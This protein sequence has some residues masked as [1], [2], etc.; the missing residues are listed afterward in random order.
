MN[1]TDV[2]GNPNTIILLPV[3]NS[4]L[5]LRKVLSSIK[6][7]VWNE[8]SHLLVLDNASCDDSIHV[9][10]DFKKTN[11]NLSH[12]IVIQTHK[13]N[14]GYGGSV[15]WGLNWALSRNVQYVMI[16]HSDDQANWGLVSKS[17]LDQRES[18]RIVIASRLHEEASMKGYSLKRNFGNRFFKIVTF[19]ATG[20]RM[21]DPGSAIVCFPTDAIIGIDFQKFDS[22]YL[23]HP[24]LNLIL[25]SNKKFE[26]K[27]IPLDWHDASTDNH[28]PLFRYGLSLMVFLFRVSVFHR[29]LRMSINKSVSRAVK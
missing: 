6:L 8:I 16:L 14:L 11:V 20:I 2:I 28:F 10:E 9:V 25:Y 19:L 22:G 24:Q 3:Y 29:V 21:N 26:F 15:V 13:S 27:E 7:E 23:F 1:E 5:Y 4:G 18:E 12:K 17:L